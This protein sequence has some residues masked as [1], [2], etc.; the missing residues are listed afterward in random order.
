MP[1]GVYERHPKP[2]IERILAKTDKA[3]P[4]P[5]DHPE[6]GPCWIWL[7]YRTIKGYG[8]IAIPPRGTAAI[9]HRMMYILHFGDIADDREVDHIC[10]VRYCVN[11]SHLR[12]ATH[13]ENL[14]NQKRSGRNKSGFKGV[15]KKGNRWVAQITK[16][17]QLWLG[18]FATPEEAYEVFCAA[19]KELHGEFCNLG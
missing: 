13:S 3:G 15:Y 11:P 9:V 1:L 6:L 19:A 12:L 4:I 18:T 10:G 5:K 7:G 17:K 8:R 16:E 2:I 14:Y